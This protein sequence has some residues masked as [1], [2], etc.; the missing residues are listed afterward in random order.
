MANAF[1][2][3]K[4]TS[5]IYLITEPY[6]R[7]HAN[8]FV[9]QGSP[10][11]LLVDAG[12][13][14]CDLNKFLLSQGFS[15]K[16]TITHGHFDHIGGLSHFPADDIIVSEKLAANV[17]KRHLWG[18][19]FLKP[20]YFDPKL[21]HEMMGKSPLEIGLDFAIRPPKA[22]PSQTSEI[23]VGKH[24]FYIISL[25]GHT[26]DSVVLYDQK[27]EILITG[28]MLYDGEIY[29]DFPNSDKAA[30]KRS[31]HYLKT[32]DFTLVLPGHNSI[33]NRAKAM[34][35]IERWESLL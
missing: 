9:M 17:R 6:F 1:K 31:L 26:D 18:L 22:I 11:D 21:T 4:I 3:E 25:P 16:V 2:I 27:N 35:V 32:L 8:L 7:E 10:F 24:L 20:E 29:A 5:D 33:L 34:R 30:F 12:L 14:L 23:D 13:G 28:D 15:P 19:D